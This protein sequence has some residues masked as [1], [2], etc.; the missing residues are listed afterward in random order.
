M[1]PNKQKKISDSDAVLF[2][3]LK[4]VVEGDKAGSGGRSYTKTLA[5]V[6]GE[7]F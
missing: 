4:R 5:K 7:D 2:K 1:I 3:S 6:V